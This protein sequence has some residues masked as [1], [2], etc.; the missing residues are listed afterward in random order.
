M[1]E[2]VNAEVTLRLQ[3]LGAIDHLAPLR[4]MSAFLRIGDVRRA[5]LKKSAMCH[6]ETFRRLAV[7]AKPGSSKGR[8]VSAGP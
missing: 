4:C 5:R 8:H 2:N 7:A 6:K 3:T 1:I